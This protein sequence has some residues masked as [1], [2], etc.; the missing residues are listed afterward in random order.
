MALYRLHDTGVIRSDGASIPADNGNRDWLA[1]LAWVALGN[2]PDP[3]NTED[4]IR[5]TLYMALQASDTVVLRCS[6]SGVPVP[7]TWKEYRSRLREALK[8]GGEPPS[9]PE[10]PDN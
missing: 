7:E 1:Y 6:E 2:T 8:T 5:G 4:T 9:K 10:Y 3:K